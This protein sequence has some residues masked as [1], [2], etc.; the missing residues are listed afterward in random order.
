MESWTVFEKGRLHF[1]VLVA[2]LLALSWQ[3]CLPSWVAS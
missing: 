3:T 1:A 2:A